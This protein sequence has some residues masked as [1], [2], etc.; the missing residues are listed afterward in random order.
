MPNNTINNNPNT[1]SVS[2]QQTQPNTSSKDN[3]TPAQKPTRSNSTAG[4]L[5]NSVQSFKATANLYSE[6]TNSQPPHLTRKQALVPNKRTL[7]AVSPTRKTSI[8]PNS[9]VAQGLQNTRL[10]NAGQNKQLIVNRGHIPSKGYGA[11]QVSLASEINQKIVQNAK[12][13]LDFYTVNT[14]FLPS[15]PEE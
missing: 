15:I 12:R 11:K 1:D 2:T 5:R 4:R 13:Q 14:G 3:M 8:R 6:G 10:L 7:Q 9:S